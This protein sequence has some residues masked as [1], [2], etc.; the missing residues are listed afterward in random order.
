ML[1]A[2]IM[3]LASTVFFGTPEEIDKKIAEARASATQQARVR[4]E[5]AI[6]RAGDPATPG[7]LTAADDPSLAQL[8]RRWSVQQAQ[9]VQKQLLTSADPAV[10]EAM[11]ASV[12]CVA[13]GGV[14]PMGFASDKKQAKRL[15]GAI[16]LA[17]CP[18]D[19][20]LFIEAMPIATAKGSGAV[21]FPE[22]YTQ[23]VAGK[24]ALRL[25]FKAAG[26]RQ[27]ESLSLLD[28]ELQ[29]NLSYWS[30]G[31][32]GQKAMTGARPL[33]TLSMPWYL[34]PPNLPEKP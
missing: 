24:P 32:S 3:L 21:V 15:S 14:Q 29:Y 1:S 8:R 13:Q 22:L 31:D 34:K 16:L 5:E 7:V 6:A 18:D 33:D 23:R 30:Q 25:Y 28:G 19:A 27:M 11:A 12:G 10:L 17:T 20:Y 2:S 4:Q 26:G 9:T